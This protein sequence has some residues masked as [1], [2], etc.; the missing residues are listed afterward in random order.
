MTNSD[1][2]AATSDKGAVIQAVC[3]GAQPVNPVHCVISDRFRFICLLIAK[4]GS[5]SLRVE[6]GQDIYDSYEQLYRLIDRQVR[7]SYFTFATI[8]DPVSR[9]LS[10]YQEISLR[11]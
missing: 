5:S 7:D 2:Q 3:S 10:A 6:F 9:L 11:F 8:R 1:H 4:N